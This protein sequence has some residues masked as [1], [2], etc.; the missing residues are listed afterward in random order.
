MLFYGFQPNH[1]LSLRIFLY[2]YHFETPIH[3][4]LLPF[5]ILFL[6]LPILFTN[7][8]NFHQL[9]RNYNR[10]VLIHSLFLPRFVYYD[11]MKL[12]QIRYLL[13]RFLSPTHF[14]LPLRL[15]LRLHHL[16][17]HLL[18]SFH[19]QVLIHYVLNYLLGFNLMIFGLF[20]L[21]FQIHLDCLIVHYSHLNY[22]SFY[23]LILI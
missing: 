15:R 6:Y 12:F 2:K 19:P 7:H 17:L 8:V 20:L 1:Y 4:E 9:W 10:F 21:Y 23:P 22:P 14:R 5:Y 16:L 11:L 3:L 18:L 13:L